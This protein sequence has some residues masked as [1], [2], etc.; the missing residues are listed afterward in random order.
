MTN[1]LV[2]VES[3]AKAKTIGK[4]LGRSYVVKATMGHFRDLPRSQFGVDIDKGFQPK[5]ITIRG[6]GA[7]LKE[8][9]DAV[10]KAD[11]VYLATDPDREGEAISWH[12]AEA[13]GIEPQNTKR[14]E[15]HEITKPAVT[16]AIKKPRHI[17]MN[18]VNAQQARRILDRIVGYKLSPLLWSKIRSGLSAGRVQSVAVKLIVDREDE[19]NAFVA[20]EYW[21]I[22]ADLAT[23]RGES[24]RAILHTV[25][26]KK[27]DLSDSAKANKLAE[28]ARA[29]SYQVREVRSKDKKRNPAPPFTTSSL[30]QEASRR[31]GFAARKTM[32]I[33]QQLYEGLDLGAEG[34]VG[35]ISYMRTD[36][37]RVSSEAQAE[38]REY[39]SSKYGQKYL[40]AQ[41]PQYKN[42]QA[43]VQDAHEAI[44]PTS[45]GRLPEKVKG[46]LTRDQQRL[47]KLIW[48][49]FV[50]SQMAS[51]QIKAITADIDA[52][53]LL[54]RATGQIIEFPGFLSLYAESTDDEKG[55]EEGVLPQMHDGEKLQLQ[56]IEPQQHFTQPPP[57][58]T[59]AMLVR[60]LEEKGIGRP[61]TYAPIIE[62]I[63]KR[64]YVFLESKRFRPTELGELVVRILEEHFPQIIGVEFTAAMEEK[65]DQIEEGNADWVQVLA[66]FYGPFEQD[67]KA[68]EK[69]LEKVE[70]K[71][72][73][74]DEIC[75]LCGR[76]MV[77]KQGRFGRFLACPGYPEC[78][79]TK[80]IQRQTGVKCPDCGG[81][82]VE[83]R[84][85]KGRLFYGCSKYPEC[86][87]V[88]WDEPAGGRCPNCNHI[89]VYKK[90][91]GEK[92]YISCSEKGCS[93]RSKL[94]AAEAEE[95]GVGNEQ[96]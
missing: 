23:G 37:T 17:N 13:L 18:L 43:R 89:L 22:H 70:V 55:E 21:T 95:A 40:P 64:N 16:D 87:F 3:P 58:Y 24:F 30:Q 63:T 65:L 39:V 60:T 57:R 66:D 14:V 78:K 92:S 91:R 35:L 68:A 96:A 56:K 51:A 74:S 77:Y 31:L 79:N 53:G 46:Y 32:M 94:P 15:F 82:I 76:R 86:E 73:E 71:D 69:V 59:E 28:R 36:S 48:E 9:K 29:A 93:Y 8:L 54:F 49:R 25:D 47:Y 81:D 38:A 50:A 42:K 62:T 61:S 52:D 7:A 75:E 1:S 26:G 80:P 20:E 11:R 44:R 85:R 72:E 41:A 45:V 12:L 27:P 2:I 34:T 4:Y 90:V 84:S 10:K 88:S 19:I 6:R 33:A 5:Y 67:L 83:R